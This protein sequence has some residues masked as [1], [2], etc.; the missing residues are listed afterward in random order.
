MRI[1]FADKFP[2]RQLDEI[3]ARGHDCELQPDLAAADLPGVIAGFNV[4]VVRSTK[5]EADTF[6]AAD[7]LELVVRAGSGYNT[8]DVVAAAERGV[9]VCNVPGKNAVAVA[10]LAFGLLLAIDRNIPDNVADLRA[11]KW[12]KSRYQKAQGLFGRV[13]GVVGLGAIGL[14]F[15]DRAHAFGMEVHAVAKARGEEATRRL[16]AIG[17]T[18]HP[19]LGD[20][21]GAVDVLS[22]H[23]PAHP[24]TRGMIG[25]DLLRHLR[26]GAIIINTARGDLVDEEALLAALD[27]GVRAGLDVYPDEPAAG[28]GEFSSALAQHP[29][30][31]GTHHIGASTEQAQHAI[32]DEVVGIV[33]AFES[34]EVRNS[35]NLDSPRGTSTLLVRHRSE[36]GVP[37]GVLK[38]LSEAGINV[39]QMENRVLSGGRA[40][41]TLQI[42]GVI[43]DGVRAG[44]MADPQVIAV[45]GEQRDEEL[46]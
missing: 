28:T 6:A 44:L 14:A 4:L 43:D 3:R 30:V 16:A 2:E 37:A 31:Y 35:V 45:S 8:I 32:A 18:Y 10:E 26:P 46:Q 33:A 11:G 1:L 34:G 27:R 38:S 21:A 42:T 9:W 13:A 39:E 20:L 5:V 29:N 24:T 19:D 23:V 25:A 12:D 22:F 41:A 15:A 17:V 7:S 40:A 36:V